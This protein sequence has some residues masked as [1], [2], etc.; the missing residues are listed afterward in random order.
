ME[1]PQPRRLSINEPILIVLYQKLDMFSY[2]SD[3][4]I[5]NKILLINIIVRTIY[6]STMK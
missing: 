2:V 4:I 1:N 5:Y 3:L 6:I